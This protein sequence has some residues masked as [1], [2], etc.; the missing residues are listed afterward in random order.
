MTTKQQ[1]PAGFKLIKTIRSHTGYARYNATLEWSDDR[2]D[3][4]VYGYL[5]TCQ[6]DGIPS[7]YAYSPAQEVNIDE[8]GRK[9]VLFETSHRCY[10]VFEV[11]PQTKIF[12]T[13][14]AATEFHIRARAA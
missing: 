14:D 9:V 12:A 13:D 3:C 10:Q 6:C 7:P 11:L 5:A 4:I 8:Q 1:T 2:E